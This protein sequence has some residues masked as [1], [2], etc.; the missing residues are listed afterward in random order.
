MLKVDPF[1]LEMVGG[2][3]KGESEAGVHRGPTEGGAWPRLKIH[4]LLMEGAGGGQKHCLS[5]YLQYA[6]GREKQFWLHLREKFACMHPTRDGIS[7][8]GRRGAAVLRDVMLNCRRPLPLCFF[9]HVIRKT[10]PSV[11]TLGMKTN[12]AIPLAGNA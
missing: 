7:W 11:C 1:R 12:G 10:I 9:V 4:R 8:E 6:G 2:E 3:K 5:N